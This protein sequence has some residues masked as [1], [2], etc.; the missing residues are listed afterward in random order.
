MAAEDVILTKRIVQLRI[1][2]ECAIGRIKEYRILQGMLPAAMWDT[3][4]Q[5]VFVCC[6]LSNFNPPLVNENN[7][8]ASEIQMKL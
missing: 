6:M 1:H 2:V 5:V 4:N 8:T 3:I 7:V